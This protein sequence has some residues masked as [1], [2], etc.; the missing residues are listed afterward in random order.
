MGQGESSLCCG[1]QDNEA[2]MISGRGRGDGERTQLRHPRVTDMV[3][4][5]SSPP[6]AQTA[7][8]DEFATMVEN[9]SDV[10]SQKS[11]ARGQQQTPRQEMYSKPTANMPMDCFGQKRNRA[12]EA[13]TSLPQQGNQ[14]MGRTAYT[15]IT[16]GA[17]SY[18]GQRS[19]A[20]DI[21]EKQQTISLLSP[22]K[23]GVQGYCSP[24]PSPTLD[25]AGSEQD[26]SWSAISERTSQ[27]S[28][29]DGLA[30]HH[31]S[32]SKVNSSLEEDEWERYEHE[33]YVSSLRPEWGRIRQVD[34]IDSVQL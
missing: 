27:P 1:G 12:Q 16:Q 32:P 5:A 11:T 17:Y 28:P 8:A 21:A 13:N 26:S 22:R 31:E 4:S 23:A 29:P 30:T 19:L 15:P 20:H 9:I 25:P 18:A 10:H 7:T 3:L 33:G 14:L 24:P 2:R 6:N 34:G